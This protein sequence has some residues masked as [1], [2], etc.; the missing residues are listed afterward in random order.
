MDIHPIGSCHSQLF[1]RGQ[2]LFLGQRF[3]HLIHRS[4]QTLDR[5]FESFKT[6]WAK[7]SEEETKVK[8]IL[9]SDSIDWT[10]VQDQVATLLISTK[11]YSRLGHLLKNLLKRASRQELKNI[12]HLSF[13]KMFD[14]SRFEYE[15]L[16]AFV[17]QETLKSFVSAQEM[18]HLRMCLSTSDL[19]SASKG[20]SQIKKTVQVVARFFSNFM[21][22][23][24]KA[25]HLI[26][27]GKGPESIFDF[28]MMLEIYFKLFMLP[29]T[30][31][32]IAGSLGLFA[33][34]ALL[35]TFTLILAGSAGTFVYLKFRP[36]P[37]KLPRASN[38]SE[39][40]SCGRFLPVV[41]RDQE[42]QTISGYLGKNEDGIVTNLIIV[43]EAGVG[44]TQLVKGLAQHNKEK[45]FFA[46]DAPDLAGPFTSIG[47]KLRFIFMDI[48]GHEDKVV[49][50]LDEFGDAIKKNPQINIT[51]YIKPFLDD[52]G[53][54][55]IAILTKEEYQ[56]LIASDMPLKDRFFIF[57]VEPTTK[58]QTLS[59]LQQR[60]ETKGHAVR[61]VPN[62][63]EEIIHQTDGKSQPRHAVKL[64]NLAMNYVRG[65]DAKTYMPNELITM[66]RELKR[67]QRDYRFALRREKHD[68]R[69]VIEKDIKTLK[70]K[71]CR[72]QEATKQL[73]VMAQKVQLLIK[74]KHVLD[75]LRERLSKEERSGNRLSFLHG[76]LCPWM[77]SKIQVLIAKH[78]EIPLQ[79]DRPLIQKIVA[80]G[81]L[82][83]SSG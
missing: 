26:D 27:A 42:I 58:E 50:V 41:E 79:I 8:A 16:Q 11:P 83:N 1:D 70:K 75:R 78:K 66:R 76:V 52:D 18:Q 22:T 34:Q 30:M 82:K 29:W 2:S 20:E 9:N 5:F 47:D 77:E 39:Q 54:Q 37:S 69:A 72:L 31:F 53:V 15:T 65:F 13:D 19:P 24:L 33:W 38:W 4:I 61:F 49:F 46:L 67:R 56:T 23:F 45:L 68:Q 48:K 73:R 64:L 35:F 36:C 25:F 10:V 44:K 51:G 12:F 74:K 62:I 80:E 40:A 71:V 21:D 60:M 7:E 59:I 28:S 55:M 6:R 17:Q 3:D 32:L 81:K 14:L 57:Q 63:A 43:G